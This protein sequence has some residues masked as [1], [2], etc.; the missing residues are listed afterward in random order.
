MEVG[1]REGGGVV[2]RVQA[3]GA[4][5][6]SVPSV[7][8]EHPN[9]PQ[10]PRKRRSQAGKEGQVTVF[11]VKRRQWHKSQRVVSALAFYRAL[12]QNL[13]PL[14]RL[15]TTWTGLFPLR[16]DPVVPLS[17][18]F[19][20]IYWFHTFNKRTKTS[21]MTAD[22]ITAAPSRCRRLEHKQTN[23]QIRQANGSLTCLSGFSV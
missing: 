10:E 18:V 7:A 19:V 1:G 16:R 11:P 2:G 22:I 20:M 12:I 21:Q 14:P 3:G 8:T 23:K 17:T 15:C 5:P 6:E 13:S 4:N 9:L